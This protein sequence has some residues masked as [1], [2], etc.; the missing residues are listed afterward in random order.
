M[1]DGPPRS[2]CRCERGTA[3]DLP[4]NGHRP[5]PARRVRQRHL[6]HRYAALEDPESYFAALALE[7]NAYYLAIRD[8][9]LKDVNPNKATIGCAEF[10]DCVAWANEAARKFVGTELVYPLPSS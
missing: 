2:G 3:E 4:T 5:R 10:P 6:P 7:A 9:Q 1:R 8:G